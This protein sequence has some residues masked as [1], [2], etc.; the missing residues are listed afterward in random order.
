MENENQT[1]YTHQKD[2]PNGASCN[3]KVSTGFGGFILAA[4]IVSAVLWLI[5]R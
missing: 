3:V 5:L 1:S 4:A 2:K